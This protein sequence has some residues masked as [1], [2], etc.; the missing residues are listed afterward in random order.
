MQKTKAL[1]I[2]DDEGDVFLIREMLDMASAPVEI[3][4]ACRLNDALML[5]ETGG[6]D[7]IISDLGLPDS[8]GLDT[9][10]ALRANDKAAPILVLTGLADE[11]TGVAALKEGAQDYLV[12]GAITGALLLRSIRYA[13][14]RK[15]IESE[16]ERLIE[17]LQ[18]ALSKVKLLSGLIPICANCKNIRNDEGYWQKVEVY[19][20]DHS[21]AK[22]S[23][24]L[25][26][27]CAKKLYPELYDPSWD[28]GS[29][30]EK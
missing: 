17:E 15:K 25:C 6:Y 20:R 28:K 26:P 8:K 18:D 21:E 22:F 2:E 29:K 9:L 13:M 10:R 11:E 24:G 12:K 1:L 30:G 16:R 5:M 4:E 19:I 27:A 3:K 14:E 7:V 23:H